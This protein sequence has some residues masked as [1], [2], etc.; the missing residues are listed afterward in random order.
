M[1][2]WIPSEKRQLIVTEWSPHD[3]Y[4]CAVVRGKRSLLGYVRVPAA[5]PWAGRDYLDVPTPPSIPNKRMS[6]KQVS[7][8]GSEVWFGFDM[9]DDRGREVGAWTNN[10][11]VD[12][13]TQVVTMFVGNGGME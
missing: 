12:I 6:F 4:A 8:D 1:T 2:F 10:E 13:C 9:N 3:G 7:E 5:H 11:M